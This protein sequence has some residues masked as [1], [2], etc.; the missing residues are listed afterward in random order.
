MASRLKKQNK[1]VNANFEASV[2]L[3]AL[4][5]Q[6]GIPDPSHV[7][8]SSEFLFQHPTLSP[9][10]PPSLFASLSTSKLF[11]SYS[12]PLIMP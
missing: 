11:F 3:Q 7:S 6:S 1:Q 10:A 4:I 12:N 5:P 8:T 9:M 2:L